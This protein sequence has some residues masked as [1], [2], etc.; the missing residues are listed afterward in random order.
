[1]PAPTFETRLRARIHDV[2]DTQDGPDPVWAEAPAATMTSDPRRSDRWP[3]RL[4]GLAA[5]LAIGGGMLSVAGSW[6]SP[7]DPAS[8]EPPPELSSPVIPAVLRGQFVAQLSVGQGA[9]NPYPFYFVDLEDP[10]LLHGPGDSEDPTTLRAEWGTS[11]AWAGRIARFSVTGPGVATAVIQAPPPC[12]DARYVV[13]YNEV[14]G[15][16][17]AQPWNLFFTEPEDTCADRV[18]ILVGGH[19]APSIAASAAPDGH[20]TPSAGPTSR[21][22]SHQPIQLV[23]GERYTSWSFTEPFRFQMP[24]VPSGAEWSPATSAWTWLA[25][26]TLR[27]SSVWWVG[28]FYDDQPLPTCD[29]ALPDIPS[30]P[31]AFESWLRSTGRSIDRSFELTVDGRPARRYDT[32]DPASDC[33]GTRE[34]R[35]FGRWYLIPTGDDTI[36]FN[37]Y[38]DTETEMQLADDIVRSMTFD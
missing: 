13:R 23:G 18:A 16:G 12:G 1:M 29:R 24:A 31:A 22:W 27:V 36:L 17:D 8:P 35:F 10:L 32:S 6:R 11:A 19:D 25:P 38:G 30:T 15:R 26:G 21:V 28:K 4:L 34:D 9:A 7:V 14:E 37:V 3:I 2:L 33:P 20:A 5:L